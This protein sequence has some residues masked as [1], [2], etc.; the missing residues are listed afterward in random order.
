MP[1]QFTMTFE[2]TNEA[3][4]EDPEIEVASLLRRIASKVESGYTSGPVRD[5]NGN[6]VGRWSL[7]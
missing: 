1:E 5:I 4:A 2:T 7:K 6:T 3:F